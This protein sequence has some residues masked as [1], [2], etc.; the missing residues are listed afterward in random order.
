MISPTVIDDF[1]ANSQYLKKSLVELKMLDSKILEVIK[2]EDIENYIVESG[3][4][5]SRHRFVI[6]MI[7]SRTRE[8]TPTIERVAPIAKPQTV[9]LPY[10]Q[11]QK[12]GGN[13]TDWT[14]FWDSF[15]SAVHNS[16][17]L[18]DVKGLNYLKSYL[19]GNPARALER[20]Q[21][22]SENYTKAVKMLCDRFGNKQVII[23]SH[24]SKFKE[25][26]IVRNIA[27]LSGLRTGYDN[28]KFN[29]RSL[30][31]V[32]ASPESHARN[33]V[34]LLPKQ[35]RIQTTASAAGA[36]VKFSD[37]CFYEKEIFT[38]RQFT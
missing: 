24:M 9:K 11:L 20:L 22:T 35:G 19:Y 3:E 32:G 27:D 31:S 18:D 38:N 21:S 37:P 25:I 28:I 34:W 33:W 5:A 13:P 15:S 7:E 16:E 36:V 2:E 1:T 17:E 14:S 12:F 8:N 10:L 26:K 4:F 29:V 23:S 30:Q 6:A